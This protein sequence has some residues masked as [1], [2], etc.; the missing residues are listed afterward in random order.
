MF[1]WG[2]ARKPPQQPSPKLTYL[3]LGDSY[4]IGEA[5]PEQDRWPVQLVDSLR[6]SGFSAETPTIIA[7][8]G[9]TTNELMEAIEEAA[10]D[11]TY[12]FVSLLI[13]VNNQ[14]RGYDI[15]QYRI[16]FELLLQHAI[17]FADNRPER[18]LVVS[19]PNYG[20]TPF[21]GS[22]NPEKISSELTMYDSIADS[23]TMQNAVTFIDI[24]DLSEN[25]EQDST[26]LAP[27]QLHPSGK[28]YAEWVSRMLPVVKSKLN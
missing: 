13:G 15:N 28:M 20:V 14:Y 26:L 4:T 22:K 5:V 12:D 25:A 1:L 2:C 19:I 23:I 17:T 18:V 3:A 24:R 21:A 27:D 8:T 9:W 16:E 6:N 10:I 7:K 11:T